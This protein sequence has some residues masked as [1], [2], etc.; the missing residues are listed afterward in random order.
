MFDAWS[1][2]DPVAVGTRLGG[3]LRRPAGERTLENKNKAISYAAYR[4]LTDLFKEREEMAVFNG[5]MAQLGYDPN[6]ETTD[7]TTAAGI[8]NVAAQ[9]VLTFRHHDGSNQLGDAWGSDGSPYSD[10]TNRTEPNTVETLSD[11]NCWQPLRVLNIW[12]G[13]DRQRFVCPQWSRV[14]P[15]ALD[16]SDQFRPTMRPAKLTD[17]ARFR[18]QADELVHIS[19]SLTDQQKA[20][21]EYWLDGPR[22]E[23]PPGHW[24][25]YAEWVSHRNHYGVD[26]D[27]K[28]F[29]ALGNAVMDA[30]ITCWDC[31]IAYDSV[32][33]ITAIHVLYAGKKIRS[34]AGPG[35]GTRKIDGADW[36][37]YQPKTVVTPAFPEFCSGHS[38]F[39]AAAAEVLKDCTGSD[40]FGYSVTIPAGH[41]RVEP[42]LTP[43]QPVTISYP[44]FTAAADDA[45][46]SRRYGGIHFADADM[47]GREIGRQTGALVWRVAQSYIKGYAP[48]PQTPQPDE[49]LPANASGPPAMGG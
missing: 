3:T 4:A 35:L 11:P 16:R 36:Q 30:G 17:T 1:A 19:A 14:I 6:D 13:Y 49:S 46:M 32:R 42:G 38:T 2:Y 27:V 20:V 45:G 28:L 26:D 37:P 15:F 31:K 9:A 24:T 25:L 21:A 8:G 29:F 5:L 41:S 7:P 23:Q 33:P 22:S 40:R 18:A 43:K 12:G 47:C 39:S 44:T 34:W 48:K 10:Y